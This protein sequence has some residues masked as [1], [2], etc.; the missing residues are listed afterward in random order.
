MGLNKDYE[1]GQGVNNLDT[2]NVSKDKDKQSV[3]ALR[4][5]GNNRK[6]EHHPILFPWNCI[7]DYLYPETK[8]LCNI[9]KMELHDQVNT[10]RTYISNVFTGKNRSKK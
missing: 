3:Y 6:Q 1:K 7:K 8:Y 10:I 2:N 4:L 9:K 5:N